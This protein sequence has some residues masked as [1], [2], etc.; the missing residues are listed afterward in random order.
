MLLLPLGTADLRYL[1]LNGPRLTSLVLMGLVGSAIPRE[2]H[3]SL[4]PVYLDPGVSS[5][6]SF[7]LVCL[8]T[9]L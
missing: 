6:L 3:L 1:I 5:S 2:S 8:L 9:G 7:L 4:W